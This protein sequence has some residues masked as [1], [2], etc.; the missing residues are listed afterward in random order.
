MSSVGAGPAAAKGEVLS[1][2]SAGRD[3]MINSWSANGDCIGSH[4]YMCIYVYVYVIL[5]FYCSVYNRSSRHGDL[6]E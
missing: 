6:P 1:F 3:S 4:E 5:Y 2:L